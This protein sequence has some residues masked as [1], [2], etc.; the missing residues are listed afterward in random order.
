M[1]RMN[2]LELMEIIK[3]RNPDIRCIILSGLNEFEHARQAIKLQVLDYVLKPIYPDVIEKVLANAVDVL[4][5][6][7][8]ETSR[9]EA[10]RKGSQRSITKF[11]R[12][13]ASCGME[14]QLFVFVW[15]KR[16]GLQCM[17]NLKKYENDCYKIIIY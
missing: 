4:R 15:K 16:R 3:S 12:N 13:H 9:F 5:K 1:P 8:E 7:R 6:E 2:G 14:R 11:G 17:M 10:R